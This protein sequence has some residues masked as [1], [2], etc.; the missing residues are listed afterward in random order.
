MVKKLLRR[1][2]EAGRER[3]FVREQRRI[4]RPLAPFVTRLRPGRLPEKPFVSYQIT[5]R[6][7]DWTDRYPAIAMVA[8]KLRAKSFTLDGKAAVSGVPQRSEEDFWLPIRHRAGDLRTVPYETIEKNQARPKS[9][10]RNSSNVCG[11]AEVSAKA[12]AVSL[13]RRPGS[14]LQRGGTLMTLW[15]LTFRDGDAVI[16]EGESISHARLLAVA[17]DLCKASHFVEGHPV[18]SA[19]VEM[20]PEDFIWRRLSRQQASDVWKV[21][22]DGPRKAA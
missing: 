13:I 3:Q 21:L 12:L 4:N 15:W 6:G 1:R 14:S 20:I 18:D 7:H 17:N 8:A 5:F 11:V 22:T 9:A 10:G 16:I 2:L 19:L